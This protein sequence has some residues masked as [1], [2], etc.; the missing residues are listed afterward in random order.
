[1]C[2]LSTLCTGL[3]PDIFRV[4]EDARLAI[5]TELDEAQR[6][7]VQDAADSCPTQAITFAG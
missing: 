6:Q 7:A 1:R 2:A 5:S 4:D 3:A